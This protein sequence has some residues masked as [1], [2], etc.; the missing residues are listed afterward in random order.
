MSLKDK[1]IRDFKEAFKG[2]EE[3]KLS[4]LKLLQAEIH[5]AEIAKRAKTG[6]EEAL[7][8]DEIIDV[9]S[10]EIKKRKDAIELYEKGGR[11]ELA[12][13]ERQEIDFLKFY[14]PEQLSEEEIRN[15]VKKAIAQTGAKEIEEMGRV[16]GVLSPQIKG[17]AD[18]GL[19]SKIVKEC[20]T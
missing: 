14:L 11:Q 2:K 5:N 20:L 1:I 9:V 16:M 7:G 15:L 12:V 10:R 4:V 3:I 6:K 19:V 18:G 13:K 17:R 8:E